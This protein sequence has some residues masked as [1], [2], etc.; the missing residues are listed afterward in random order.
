MDMKTTPG[1]GELANLN[2][3]QRHQA[4]QLLFE[5]ENGLLAFRDAVQSYYCWTAT[6]TGLCQGG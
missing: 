2:H 5:S 3:A 4:Q 6:R 1:E